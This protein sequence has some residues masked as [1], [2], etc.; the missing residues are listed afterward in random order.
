MFSFIAFLIPFFLIFCWICYRRTIVNIAE[1]KLQ[2]AFVCRCP[3]E[4]IPNA[5]LASPTQDRLRLV[6]K[7][8]NIFYPWDTFILECDS[9]EYFYTKPFFVRKAIQYTLD[10][11]G[12]VLEPD[13]PIIH[14]AF[15]ATRDFAKE[16]YKQKAVEPTDLITTQRTFVVEKGMFFMSMFK[17]AN[18]GFP[19][20]ALPLPGTELLDGVVAGLC[21]NQKNGKGPKWRV[22]DGRIHDVD[23]IIQ[24][25]CAALVLNIYAQCDGKYID[26]QNFR[27]VDE[28]T[29]IT[30]VY[31]PIGDIT[32]DR[33]RNLP[34][35]FQVEMLIQNYIA[36]T[37]KDKS[38]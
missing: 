10:H 32:L 17:R 11:Y 2:L 8:K 28:K 25:D 12:F 35:T 6:V 13:Y 7:L 15:N 19:S 24:L 38:E 1:K 29:F 31:V 9:S 30:V 21:Y 4:N 26:I 37:L 22:M 18:V 16:R 27:R 14:H 33:Y 20:L 3:Y 23:A 5:L 36:D 34:N